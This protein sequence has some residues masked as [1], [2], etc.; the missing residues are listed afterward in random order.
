MHL[1]RI[2]KDNNGL[3]VGHCDCSIVWSCSRWR[4]AFD[5]GFNHVRHRRRFDEVGR[6][7]VGFRSVRHDK[8]T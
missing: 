5:Y 6:G 4:N 8:D 2:A 7:M 3:W 1:A